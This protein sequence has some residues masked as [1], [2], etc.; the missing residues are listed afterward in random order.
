MDGAA[1]ERQMAK[2]I[3]AQVRDGVSS[4][5]ERRA[6][7]SSAFIVSSQRDFEGVRAKSSTQ[8]R[9]GRSTPP[10]SEKKSSAD[11]PSGEAVPVNEAGQAPPDDSSPDRENETLFKPASTLAALHSIGDIWETDSIMIYLDYVFPFLFPFYRPPLVGTSRAWLL[12]FISQNATVY[13]SVLSLSAY[14]FTI[15]LKDVFPEERYVC[16]SVMWAQAVKQ[17]DKCFETIRKDLMETTASELRTTLFNK[18]RIMQSIIHLLMFELFIGNS[19]N[20]ISHLTPALAIFEDVVEQYSQFSPEKLGLECVLEQLPG[21][22]SSYP[23]VLRPLWNPNQSAFRFFTAALL[24]IDIVASTSLERAPVLRSYQSRLLADLAPD[25]VATSL[26]LSSFV[27]CE[28]WVLIAVGDISALDAAKKE[29]ESAG[30]AFLPELL[31]RASRIFKTLETGIAKLRADQL[32]IS[33]RDNISGSKFDPLQPYFHA[34]LHLTGKRLSAAP[35]RIWAHAARIYLSV[36]VSGWI[37][38]D[39][40]IRQDVA[41]I[42]SLLRHVDSAAQMHTFAWPVCVAGCLAQGDAEQEEFVAIITET[43]NPQLL[44]ALHESRR[45]ME[46]VWMMRGPRDGETWDIATC[47]RVMGS[48][49]LLV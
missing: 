23:G 33:N 45:I 2:T 6:R 41:Q 16:K 46:A 9:F 21:P 5:R 3:K 40:Q 32:H 28:N 37:P 29:M 30:R 22:P 42:L 1:R 43:G 18:A 14:F 39:A 12:P 25:Q 47:L 38:S 4:R 20:W 27:G 48:P 8:V 19:N 31:E 49:A 7:T 35:T 34:N 17:A 24:Y 44:S 11:K 13:S 36:V 10:S 15:A 26:D